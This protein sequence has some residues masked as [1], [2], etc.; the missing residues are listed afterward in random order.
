[1]EGKM[2]YKCEQCHDTGWY[3]DNGPGIKGNREYQPCECQGTTK[4]VRM[5][6]D[7]TAKKEMPETCP[8]RLEDRH[9]GYLEQVLRNTLQAD[10]ST[11][12]TEY[13][14]VERFIESIGFHYRTA[15]VHGY[16]HGQA[17]AQARIR[18]LEAEVERMKK[19][20]GY[21]SAGLTEEEMKKILEVK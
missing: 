3:G 9:W 15:M 17:D 5:E 2:P 21:Y 8:E 14:K 11:D 16:K 19:E 12:E 18:E 13:D 20:F 4:D 6:N 7:N 1:M 10:Y